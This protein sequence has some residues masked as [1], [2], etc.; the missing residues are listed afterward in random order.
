MFKVETE[1]MNIPYQIL[2]DE[3]MYVRR[4]TVTEFYVI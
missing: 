3:N 2:G 1:L 4:I